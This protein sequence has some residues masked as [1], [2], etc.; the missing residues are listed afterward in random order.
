MSHLK[1]ARLCSWNLNGLRSVTGKGF[2]SWLREE[3]PLIL[4]VQEIKCVPEQVT[5]LIERLSDSYEVV[6]APAEKKGYSGVG[7]FYSKENPPLKI[8]IGL[9]LP[10]FD[11]EGRTIIAHY[12]QLIVLNGYFPNGQRDH[13]RVD[14]KLAYSR[15][16]LKHAK[17][18][19]KK[20]GKEIVIMGDF[21]TAHH[22]IDL[23]NPKSNTKTTGFL[24]HERVFLDECQAAGLH[25]IFRER[26]G[27]QNGH[28]TWWTYRGD[29]RERNIGWRIDY[30]FISEAL[31]EKVIECENLTHIMGSDHCPLRLTLKF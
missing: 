26:T 3:K 7:Y 9:S 28:Y 17:D 12:D 24:P 16:M 10:E 20:T 1:S 15:A 30:F 14:Y 6:L 2:E 22:E 25:D 8:E 21:N 4:G 19:Q 11:C 27:P 31:R 23:A 18:L 5:D 13:S 29:C